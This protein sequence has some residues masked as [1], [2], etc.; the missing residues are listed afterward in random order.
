[1]RKLI[2]VSLLLIF[3]ACT[4][5]PPIPAGTPAPSATPS[6]TFSVQTHPDGPLYVGD[7]V[8][9]EVLSPSSFK[10][11]S[12]SIRISLADKSLDEKKFAPFGVG[13]R[14]QASFYWVW[15]THGLQAGD[16]TL[17]FSL[18][19]DGT[20]WNETI[21]L[22]PA[23]ELPSGEVGA[24]WKETESVCC[25]IHY[26][27][28]TDSEKDI[29]TLKSML[30]T[31]AA[32][33]E[34]RMKAKFK[35]KIPFTF[36][37]RTLGHGGF[38]SDGIYVSYLRQNYA[39]ST[40]QQVAHHEMVH[41]LDSQLGGGMRPTILTEGLAVY[42]S[43][44]HFKVEPILP[45]A[46][47]V[48]DL[49][50]Y[51]PLRQLSNSFYISQ[52]EIGY[53]EAAALVSYLVSTYGWDEFNTFYRDIH[54]AASGSQ[55]DA[56]E[57]A[58]QAHFKVSFD[59]LEKNFTEALRQQKID[60]ATHSDLRLTV[61]FY[62]T[63]RR[64]QREMDPSAYFLNA[65]LPDVPSMREQGIVADF[66]RH[67]TTQA[68]QQIESLLV[69]GDASLRSANYKDAESNIRAVNFLLDLLERL[70]KQGTNMIIPRLKKASV[71]RPL[72]YWH[73]V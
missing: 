32:D 73:S 57:A 10:P 7:R 53:I 71:W 58:L 15:D 23:A 49:G 30:D 2:I 39:G 52:H 40:T 61:A 9:F 47:A 36:L 66:L 70:K 41:W 27:T 24:V 31:Q 29:E 34:L 25:A 18:L 65:W 13:G 51:I 45:R 20:H 14:S 43:D 68:A 48:I 8:S 3:A 54:P 6:S 37:P 22:H 42:L 63:V 16:Y 4:P 64:Y 56:L 46:A 11:E 19:P 50:W 44:G 17:T 35:G 5:L 26:I 55:A 38:T 72:N 69:A 67:P 12:K 62:D 59:Q 1:M 28:G 33:V 21:K 60:D